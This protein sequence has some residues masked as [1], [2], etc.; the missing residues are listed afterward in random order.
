MAT[1]DKEFAHESVQD[2]NSVV[3][4]LSAVGEGIEQG[5]L[6]LST[7]GEKF[8]LEAPPLLRFDVR[9]KQKR[10]RAEIVIKIG[11][12]SHKRSRE[13]KVESAGS[14]EETGPDKA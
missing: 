8:V 6:L 10:N 13:L 9:A 7:N 12:K 11:W 5:R 3:R 4:Y 14:E 2:R 1:E